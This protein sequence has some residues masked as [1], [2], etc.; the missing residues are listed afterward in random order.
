MSSLS[1]QNLR[2]CENLLLHVKVEGCRH[3]SESYRS[4]LQWISERLSCG[5][6]PSYQ[7]PA[8]V[9][10]DI[11]TMFEASQD[12][13]LDELQKS[14]QRKLKET[15]SSELHPSVLTPPQSRPANDSL[16]GSST[17]DKTMDKD[18]Q[19]KILQIRK[20]LRELLDVKN[21]PRTKM[22]KMD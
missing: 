2:R 20:R 16:N 11:W 14:F 12:N 15:L 17:T 3:L 7:T 21:P 5:Q 18:K 9:V 10:S 8:Q 1:L 22:T 4:H 19:S 13:A 6:L